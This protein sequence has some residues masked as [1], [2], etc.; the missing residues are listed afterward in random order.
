MC[1]LR[2]ENL[3]QGHCVSLC[4]REAEALCLDGMHYWM[5]L[6]YNIGMNTVTNHVV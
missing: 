4:S 2:R 5:L 3:G 1:T 6:L